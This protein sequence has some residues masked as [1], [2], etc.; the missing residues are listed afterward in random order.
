MATSELAPDPAHEHAVRDGVLRL[1]RAG[2]RVRWDAL[3]DERH[4]LGFKG[5]PGRGLRYVYEHAGKWLALI[6]WQVG[7]WKCQRRDRWIGWKPEMQMERL[8]LVSNN[9]RF[10]IL[11]KGAGVPNLGS[12]VLGLNLRRLSADWHEVHGHCLE[13]AE[14]FVDPTLFHG[15]VY[16]A[17]NWIRVGRTCGYSRCTGGYTGARDVPKEMFVYP[18]NPDARARLCGAEE[19]PQWRPA[20]HLPNCSGAEL[21]SLHDLFGEVPDPRRRR[22]VRH[23]LPAILSLYMLG[24]LCGWHGPVA[25]EELGKAMS[26]DDLE[27]IGARFDRKT[28]RYIPASAATICRVMQHVDPDALQRVLLIWAAQ[29][30]IDIAAGSGPQAGERLALAA[31]GKRI[32][33]ANRNTPE[34]VQYETITLVLH[35]CAKPLAMRIYREEG[36]ELAAFKALLE[37][38]DVRGRLITVDALHATFEMEQRIVDMH[39][40]D[41]LFTIKKDCPDTFAALREVDWKTTATGTFTEDVDKAHGR[42][43]QRAIHVFSPLKGALTFRRAKQAFR[44][45]RDRTIVKTGERSIEVAY[46]ITSLGAEHATPE[47]LLKWNRGHWAVESH[48]HVRDVSMN[49]DASRAWANHAPSNNAIL[50]N[51]ALAVIRRTFPGDNV[52]KAHRAFQMNPKMRLNAVCGVA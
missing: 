17:S 8:H 14:T 49:E 33:G 22:G 36:G 1:A 15:G 40:A 11:P 25:V 45:V 20:P 27:A 6:G 48:H 26:Q 21:R 47:Q 13:L 16:D 31:D 24:R 50:N 4:Y 39:G 23:K 28:E 18:L 7:A 12:R 46:G 2:E 32:R 42:I 43:E 51:V 30:G 37:D 5:F 19:H 35:G 44:I 29:W 38:V 3:M 9:A 52:P 34:G 41:Y 10:L